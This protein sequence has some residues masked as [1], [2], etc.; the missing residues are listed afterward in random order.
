MSKAII[1][2]TSIEI[3]K[4]LMNFEQDQFKMDLVKVT[5]AKMM[6]GMETPM[7]ASSK[8]KEHAA[9]SARRSIRL[10][11]KL[12]DLSD[13][14]NP[15]VVLENRPLTT[16]G[17][18]TLLDRFP[19][20]ER[21]ICQILPWLRE[22]SDIL[23]RTIKLEVIFKMEVIMCRF[24]HLDILFPVEYPK[25]ALQICQNMYQNQYMKYKQ[26]KLEQLLKEEKENTHKVTNPTKPPIQA[27]AEQDDS[28]KSQL[29]PAKSS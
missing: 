18:V 24:L 6:M 5:E 22:P 12:T 20:S 28:S 16:T 1:G 29:K 27:A 17:S 4:N 26:N 7:P 15:F 14:R 19:H 13:P 2:G 25:I 9:L 8:I 21:D 11:L 10:T 23:K 3:K